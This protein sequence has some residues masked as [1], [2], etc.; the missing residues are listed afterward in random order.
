MASIY[1]GLLYSKTFV[2]TSIKA[3]DRYWALLGVEIRGYTIIDPGA[4]FEGFYW[5]GFFNRED[6]PYHRLNL[7]HFEGRAHEL[8]KVQHVL[9]D[10]NRVHVHQIQ[11]GFTAPRQLV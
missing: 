11:D 4:R 2:R 8:E 6:I 3:M 10:F 1:L 7:P 9:R 5:S